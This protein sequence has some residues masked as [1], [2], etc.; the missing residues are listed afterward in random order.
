MNPVLQH[1]TIRRIFVGIIGGDGI[2]TG[3]PESADA[4]NHRHLTLFLSDRIPSDDG[5]GAPVV[6]P[7]GEE[8]VQGGRDRSARMSAEAARAPAPPSACRPRR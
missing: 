6:L 3:K 2:S 5:D 1:H 8:E 4:A 7:G